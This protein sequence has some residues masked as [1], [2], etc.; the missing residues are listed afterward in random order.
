MVVM[1]PPDRVTRSQHLQLHVVLC[2]NDSVLQARLIFTYRLHEL[3]GKVPKLQAFFLEQDGRRLCDLDPVV[4]LDTL[5][6]VHFVRV[7]SDSEF[8]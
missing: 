8:T 1:V 3:T 5:L 6:P 4:T 7:A 2:P